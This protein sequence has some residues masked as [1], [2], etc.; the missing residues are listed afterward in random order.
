MSDK[1]PPVCS[2]ACRVPGYQY[3]WKMCAEPPTV[4][5]DKLTSVEVED[6]DQVVKN[7]CARHAAA[8]GVK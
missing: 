1:K 6:S 4:E 7:L 2:V 5:L 8:A 3:G